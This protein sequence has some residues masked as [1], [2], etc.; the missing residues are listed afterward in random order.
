MVVEIEKIV[1]LD[2]FIGKVDEMWMNIDGLRIGKKCVFFGVIG[3]IY[4]F[5]LNVMID[6]VS[7]V[8]K[9]GNVVI[10]CGGKEVFFLN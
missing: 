5:C 9:L 3:I 1:L 6:V 10:F 8:F 7:L 4:E 2:D